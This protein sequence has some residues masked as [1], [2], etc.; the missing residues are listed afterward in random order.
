M[1]TIDEMNDLYVCYECG[2]SKWVPKLRDRMGLDI[3]LCQ[4]GYDYNPVHMTKIKKKRK[5]K[6]G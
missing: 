5:R 2:N 3:C 6:K 1:N 4:S